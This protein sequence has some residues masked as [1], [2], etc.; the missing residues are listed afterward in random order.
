[1]GWRLTVLVGMLQA[2]PA[3]AAPFAWLAHQSVDR[4]ARIDLATHET[5]SVAVGS[6]PLSTAASLDG[7]RAY[8]NNTGDSTI[9]VI[10]AQTVSVVA[11]VPLPS[12]PTA[13]AVRADGAKAYAPLADGTVAVL[14]TGTNTV[15]SYISL[16]TFLL[17]GA[18]VTNAAGTRAYLPKSQV[19]PRRADVQALA[20]RFGV[21]D[22]RV[23]R[24][25]PAP[26]PPGS[27]Q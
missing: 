9:S 24:L 22:R 15:T 25:A 16:G 27:Q 20:R 8:T 3:A 18:I 5:V 13:I 19:D 23:L 1:M 10:D 2:M 21:A 4:A 14:D 7:L 6:Q 17:A 11:T 12:Q 26:P